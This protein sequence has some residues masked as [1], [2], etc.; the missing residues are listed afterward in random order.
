MRALILGSSLCIMKKI[1]FVRSSM[2]SI[3]NFL[4]RMIRFCRK[5]QVWLLSA[6]VLLGCLAML[7]GSCITNWYEV[8]QYVVLFDIRYIILNFLTLGV[9]WVLFFVIGRRAW[10]ADLICSLLFGCLAIANHYVIS[11]HTMPLSFLLINNFTTAMNVISGYNFTLSLPVILILAALVVL[12]VICL[13]V[14]RKE[15]ADAAKPAGRRSFRVVRDLL[16]ILM[17]AGVL[18]FGYFS[19]DPIK[20]KKTIGWLWNEAYNTYGYLPCSI[21]SLVQLLTVTNEPDGYSQEALDRIRIDHR[22][23]AAETLPDVILILNES[24]YDLRQITDVETDVPYLETVETME[25]LLSGYA[26]VPGAGGSTNSSEYEL[27]TS[28]SMWLMP[29]VT[30]FN[31]MNLQNANSVVSHLAGLGYSTLACHPE[32]SANYSRVMAYPLLGFQASY[33]EPDFENREYY[34]DRVMETD[35]CTYRNLIRWYEAQR[36]DRPRFLY[37]LTLQNHG[38]WDVN[39]AEADTVHVTNDFGDY[40]GQVNEYLSCISLS[41]RAFGELTDYFSAVDRP[42]IVCMVGDHAPKFASSVTDPSLSAEEKALNVRKVP[43][44]IWANFDLPDAD[45]GTM[46][47]NYVIPSL[48]ETAGVPLTPYYSYMLQL[49]EQIPI[50]TAY[51]SY[52]DAKGNLYTYD[53]DNGAAYESAVNDYFYLEYHNLQKDRRQSLFQPYP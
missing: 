17:S 9:F 25:N 34:A 46:S 22:E 15:R 41:D 19:P 32:P 8:Y 2:K 37:T 24:F 31:T 33:F 39:P 14:R 4:Q 6:V 49:K 45:L 29:G 1:V 35:E 30:P 27:L 20:P 40:T 43:L 23:T 52:Y 47:M 26:V 44:L 18:Y 28:N 10:I 50:L 16:L 7:E 3:P 36:E 12:L 42:V 5:Y 11:F 51:G 48:L 38:G 21:E 13:M 53:S